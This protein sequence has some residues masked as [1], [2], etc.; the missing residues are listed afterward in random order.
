[1]LGAVSSQPVRFLNLAER[2]HLNDSRRTDWLS[3]DALATAVTLDPSLLGQASEC[4]NAVTEVQGERARGSLFVDYNGLLKDA[5][6]NVVIVERV[7]VLRYK[8]ML[9]ALLT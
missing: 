3:A 5:P 9:L 2:A 6:C 7:D 8:R 1:V 4:Y